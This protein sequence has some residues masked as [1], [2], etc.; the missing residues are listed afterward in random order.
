[1]LTC[2]DSAQGP[3]C[4]LPSCFLKTLFRWFTP[5]L[6]NRVTPRH[7]HMPAPLSRAT[8]TSTAAAC[9]PGCSTHGV[10]DPIGRRCQCPLTRV[11]ASCSEL[12]LPAC[13][14]DGQPLRPTHLLHKGWERR[15]NQHQWIGPLT[16]ACVEQMAR[17]R[18]LVIY[19]NPWVAKPRHQI[20]CAR[21]AAGEDV[22]ALLA[23]PQNATWATLT[24]SLRGTSMTSVTAVRPPPVD[25]LGWFEARPERGRTPPMPA[26]VERQ[27]RAL[28]PLDHC[29]GRCGG[30][31][32]CVRAEGGR[33]MQR[34]GRMVL[35]RG[36]SGGG[37]R[38]ECYAPAV[39][40]ERGSCADRPRPR[41]TMAPNSRTVHGAE[42]CPAMCSGRGACDHEGFCHCPDGYFGLDCALALSA[43]GEPYVAGSGS[44][45]GSGSA[46]QGS[47]G[48]GGQGGRGAA[49]PR[50]APHLPL[51]CIYVY[52]LPP[53]LRLGDSFEVQLDW[54]L[55]LRLL[56]HPARCA[57]IRRADYFW[58]MGPNNAGPLLDKLNWAR[59]EW[60]YWN[61]SV[62]RGAGAR[63]ITML[64]TERGPGDIFPNEELTLRASAAT[65]N[66]S[67][68]GGGVGG[69]GGGGRFGRLRL[70]PELNPASPTREWLILTHNGMA[71]MRD[72]GRNAGRCL[73]CYQPGKDIVIP[74]PPATIDVPDCATLR[75]ISIWSPQRQ[76]MPGGGAAGT[77]GTAGAAGAA[78]DATAAAPR[79]AV[80]AGA[81]RDT[82][83]FFAGRM[84]PSMRHATY[85]TYYEGPETR[86]VRADL[87][88]H[89][90]EP[91]FKVVN[92]YTPPKN[93][94]LAHALTMPAAAAA[95][96]R[97][98]G[99]RLSKLGGGK[100]AG[101]L[102]GGK[103]AGKAAAGKAAAGKAAPGKAAPGKGDGTKPTRVDAN[104]WMQRSHFC[105]V[106]PGQRYGDARRHIIAAFH[107]CIPVL[108][109]P[110]G[111]H[112]LEEVL[113]W[114]RMALSVSQEQ[115]PHLPAILRNVSA[116]ERDAMRREL[117]CAWRRLWFSSIYGSCLGEET[118]TDAF[119]ALVQTLA[120][121]LRRGEGGAPSQPPPSLRQRPTR[122]AGSRRRQWL[123]RTACGVGGADEYD[124]R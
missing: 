72:R 102:F 37:G 119:D 44:G 113:P 27:V 29:P 75:K 50:G 106:P 107:G 60:P 110:D 93:R 65:S 42:L 11:G 115:L 105:W 94:L 41:R 22:G 59:R 111:H 23:A 101:R 61:A 51:P 12:A 2:T 66:G 30:R 116:E 36:E 77:A 1:M 92:S 87:L 32:S 45:S 26:T 62:A 98:G 69:R 43:A 25:G 95:A 117:S 53:M 85:L 112:T 40:D 63:H 109:V 58:L 19:S 13:A 86:H 38:C 33:A 81:G 82:L 79:E 39:A 4:S 120:N 123:S 78:A 15:L 31:G 103:G 17:F 88:Q 55:T 16:C 90:H 35:G 49:K 34:L 10:C 20:F 52:D 14:I 76:Q 91:D 56:A 97:G 48:G 18:N 47:S 68:G 122:G 71:D 7:N 100:A 5:Y 54:A 64:L 24:M 6:Q 118:Q 9:P 8:T 121:R 114:E 83:F 28:V 108:S 104:E 46:A 96:A 89:A 73:N 67:E 80:D 70:G 84:H 3:R 124:G 99:R 57:D 21:P 74:F